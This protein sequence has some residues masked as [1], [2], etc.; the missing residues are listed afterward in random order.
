MRDPRFWVIPALVSALALVGG[1]AAA[2]HGMDQA[3]GGGQVVF[4]ASDLERAGD[5]IG[6]TA[7]GGDFGASGQFTYVATSLAGAEMDRWQGQVDCL[8]VEGDTAEL[9]GEIRSNPGSTVSGRFAVL[10]KDNGEPTEGQGT[11]TILIK[12]GEDV[13]G[14]CEEDWSE[15][16]EL[17]LARGNARVHDGGS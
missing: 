9:G 12:Y 16:T 15:V 8:V 14:E 3:H 6:F 5:T 2:D 4:D 13:E 17:V 11:D 1:A 10:V 7:Q